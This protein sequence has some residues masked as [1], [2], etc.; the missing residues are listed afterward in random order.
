MIRVAVHACPR[1]RPGPAGANSEM[2]PTSTG[3]PLIQRDTSSQRGKQYAPTGYSHTQKRSSRGGPASAET[4]RRT[5]VHSASDHT[6]A[7]RRLSQRGSARAAACPV[8][9][10][11]EGRVF[12]CCCCTAES[13][14]CAST[15]IGA[16]IQTLTPL[17][18]PDLHSCGRP[19]IAHSL[20]RIFWCL[21]TGPGWQDIVG[22]ITCGSDFAL[23][24]KNRQASL[25]ILAR[26]RVPVEAEYLA[27]VHRTSTGF[28]KYRRFGSTH[29][30]THTH[31]HMHSV[32]MC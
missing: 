18:T 31:K 29:T 30:H 22:S 13:S 6:K 2:L 12:G 5:R 21:P 10:L 23:S 25:V 1:F 19:G 24:W 11:R 15:V 32:H 27:T 8:D 26:Q 17:L 9:V 4:P 3:K 7:R 28:V 14:A 20:L 16:H